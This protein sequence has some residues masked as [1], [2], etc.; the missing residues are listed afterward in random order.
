[1]LAAC[2]DETNEIM[3]H[4]AIFEQRDDDLDGYDSSRR[5]R[6]LNLITAA[7]TLAMINQQQLQLISYKDL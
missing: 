4:P 3:C 5:Q 7:E 1:L 6:D 2:A